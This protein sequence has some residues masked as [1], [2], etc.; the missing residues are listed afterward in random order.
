MAINQKNT[1][2]F[3]ILAKRHNHHE[4]KPDQ[5]KQRDSF[6]NNW[7]VVFKFQDDES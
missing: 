7:P 5:S 1:I 4:E 2:S 3:Q 6:Q